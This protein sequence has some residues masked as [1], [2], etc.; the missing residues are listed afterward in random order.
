MGYFFFILE[1]KAKKAAQ[2][3]KIACK[4]LPQSVG[5]KTLTRWFKFYLDMGMVPAYIA[6]KFGRKWRTKGGSAI[7][8]ETEVAEFELWL[9]KEPVMYLDEM[10]DFMKLRFHKS[11]SLSCMSRLLKSRGLTR[12][13]V[14]EK[15]SQAIQFRKDLFVSALRSSVTSPEMALFIDESSKDRLCARRTY[16]WSRRGKRVSYHAPFNMDTRYTLIGAADCFGFVRPMCSVVM[17]KVSGKEVSNNCD[18][19]SFVEHMRTNVAPLLGNFGRGEAHSVVVMDN[20]SIHMR[21]EVEELIR[22]AGAILIYSAPFSPELIPIEA[23]FKQWKDYLKRHF[24]EFAADWRTVHELGLAC[25][26]PEDGLNYFRMTTLD[27]LVDNHPLLT[28]SNDDDD[29]VVLLAL[30]I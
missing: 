19:D 28:K 21:A 30:L 12:K 26:T 9:E 2:M 14:Y 20:C 22:D 10:V 27:E 3:T 6:K 29:V 16:G 11:C 25:V 7:F 15:A 23:M 13:K 5:V 17:H 18:G 24:K 8:T 1:K 4:L